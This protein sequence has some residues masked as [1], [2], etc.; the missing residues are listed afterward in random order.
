HPQYTTHCLKKLDSPRVPVLMGYRIP[1]SDLQSDE[2]K[3]AV[4]LLTLFKPWSNTKSSPLKSP[5]TPWINALADFKA[6]MSSEHTRIVLNMQ[7][8]YQTRDAKFDF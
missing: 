7:L 8:L 1:L 4:A 5:E 3:Y 2:L 6:S